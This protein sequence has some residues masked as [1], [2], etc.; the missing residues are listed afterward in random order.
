MKDSKFLYDPIGKGRISTEGLGAGNV[1][2]GNRWMRHLSRAADLLKEGITVLDYGCGNARLGNFMSCFLKEFTYF[3]LEMPTNHGRLH[4]ENAQRWIGHDQ[5]IFLG[6]LDRSGLLES[7]LSQV[8]VVVLGSIVSH[9]D[10][11]DSIEV[12]LKLKPVVD[13]GARVV[14]SCCILPERLAS[15][16]R[17]VYGVKGS[18]G[19]FFHSPSLLQAVFEEVGPLLKADN[20]YKDKRYPHSFYVIERERHLRHRPGT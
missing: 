14:F 3:G 20:V 16:D 12:L 1:R 18:Y 13:R 11:E 17:D 10:Q 8:D 9:L 7:I 6:Y 15:T 19:F 4:I 5:R 2:Q